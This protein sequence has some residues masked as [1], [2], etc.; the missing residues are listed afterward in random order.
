MFAAVAVLDTSERGRRCIRRVSPARNPVLRK[1]QHMNAYPNTDLH[2]RRMGAVA[3]ILALIVL[4][5]ALAFAASPDKAAAPDQFAI[6]QP[7]LAP[8]GPARAMALHRAPG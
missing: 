6:E 3:A 2:P 8:T 7:A 1:E 5:T 4:V